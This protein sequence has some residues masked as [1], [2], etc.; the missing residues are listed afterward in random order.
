MSHNITQ[1]RRNI[2]HHPPELAPRGKILTIFT[3]LSPG[4]SVG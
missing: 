4:S 2:S 3:S 1:S